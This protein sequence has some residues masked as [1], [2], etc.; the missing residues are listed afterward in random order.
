MVRV[1]DANATPQ[2][3]IGELPRIKADSRTSVQIFEFA[4][5]QPARFS[6]TLWKKWTK[7]QLRTSD[8]PCTAASSTYRSPTYNKHRDTHTPVFKMADTLEENYMLDENDAGSVIGSDDGA[9][10]IQDEPELVPDVDDGQTAPKQPTSQE[11]KD[12]AAQKAEKKRKR[13]EKEKARKQ[14]VSSPL[15]SHNSRCARILYAQYSN[16]GLSSADSFILALAASCTL[17]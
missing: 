7:V 16:F 11:S 13:K 9:V 12:E 1:Q 5:L 3:Q 6:S 15:T 2:Q 8:L 10:S 4:S 17:R 14:K